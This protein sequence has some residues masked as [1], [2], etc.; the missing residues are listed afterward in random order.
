M[1]GLVLVLER[2]AFRSQTSISVQIRLTTIGRICIIEWHLKRCDMARCAMVNGGGGD[3]IAEVFYRVC[4]FPPRT[5]WRRETKC[6]AAE[7]KNR[8]V[9][10]CACVSNWITPSSK[11]F[12]ELTLS[13]GSDFKYRKRIYTY[14]IVV[15]ENLVIDAVFTWGW[16]WG[17]EKRRQ[18]A[19]IFRSEMWSTEMLFESLDNPSQKFP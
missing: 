2:C 11:C 7:R 12:C 16:A 17:C 5:I 13:K 15:C 19:P 14:N 8:A 10:V 1:W 9:C 3:S 4:H 18:A 6:Q